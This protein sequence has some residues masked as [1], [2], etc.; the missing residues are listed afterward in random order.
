MSLLSDIRVMELSAGLGGAFCG[1]LFAGMGADVV[2]VEPPRTGNDV[3]WQPPFLNDTPHPEGSG[4]FLYLGQG[5]R[6]LTLD[7]A[8]PD[9]AAIFEQLLQGADI[10]IEAADAPSGLPERGL[11]NEKLVRVT[12]RKFSPGGPYSDYATTELQ[13]AALGGW[14]IQVGEPNRT[15]LV[16]NSRTLS[17]L[18]PGIMAAI[19]ALAAVL[20]ARETGAGAHLD[21]SAHESLLFTTRYNETYYSYTKTEIKRYGRSF[22]GW[23]P[24]YRI[25]DSA[26]GY[27]TS[28][29]STDAQVEL[30]M[31]L[32]GV[33]ASR[34]PDRDT[35]Y[36]NAEAFVSEVGAWFRSLS[37]KEAFQQAQ[38][39]RIPV[40][41]V[42]TIDELVHLEQ[43]V[44]R[45]FFATVDH[46]IAGERVYPGN[47]IRSTGITR[48]D[49]PRAPLLGEHLADILC[50]EMGYSRED[51][52]A[53]E[54]L[55][56]I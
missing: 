35:R 47:P 36:Q 32:S 1:K 4:L 14:M 8:T 49:P 12:L 42:S 19:A 53:L 27:I 38:E 30:L 7:P 56:V 45:N 29:A 26:D 21:L 31:A 16:T 18:V 9:G 25:F 54:R 41:N 39:W 52:Q 51:L 50:D 48:Q 3:R 23:S 46:P 33:D 2:L 28:A 17:A 40:G 6:S 10:L 11:P 37:G 44:A 24:T 22:A 15:P 34:Y 43:L 13:L 55:G 20:Q 5:K